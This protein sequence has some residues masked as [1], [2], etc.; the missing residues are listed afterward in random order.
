[1]TLDGLSLPPPEDGRLPLSKGAARIAL[2]RAAG[3]RVPG[4]EELMASYRDR[5]FTEVL[6]ALARRKRSWAKSRPGGQLF[7]VTLV[8]DATIEAAKAA[9]LPDSVLRAA[10]ADQA[11]IMARRLAGR[12]RY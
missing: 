9:P 8:S 5:Y 4:Q 2:A 12:Q 7:P 10:V 6:P 1:V 3:V 11:T